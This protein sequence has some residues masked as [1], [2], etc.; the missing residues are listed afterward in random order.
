M[1]GKLVL[2]SILFVSELL[3][4]SG[5]VGISF[6]FELSLPD[7][8]SFELF[9]LGYSG[10]V[11]LFFSDLLELLSLDELSCALSSLGFSGGVPLFFSV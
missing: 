1:I 9:P 11:P 10:C 7:E 5:G 6:W 4:M 2:C 8:L 3:F